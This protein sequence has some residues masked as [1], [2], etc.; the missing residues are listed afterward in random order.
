MHQQILVMYI[1]ELN[2]NMTKEHQNLFWLDTHVKREIASLPSNV[3]ISTTT[4]L[5][6]DEY[7]AEQAY[8]KETVDILSGGIEALSDDIQQLSNESLQ[9]SLLIEAS[10]Q[11]LEIL[12]SSCEES[13]A[14][15][16]AYRTNMEILQQ[17]CVSLKQKVMESQSTSYDGTLI[18][19]ITNV[20]EKISKYIN[21]SVL[22]QCVQFSVFC[23]NYTE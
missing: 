18:W 15:L 2:A 13:N 8:I 6:T 21:F 9:Q 17:D 19:K 10:S 14:S 12:K 11:N 5:V 3:T 20:K 22:M 16:N 4:N 23:I 1:S 7:N